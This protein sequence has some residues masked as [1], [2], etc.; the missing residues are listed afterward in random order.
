VAASHPFFIKQG[1][2]LSVPLQVLQD[3]GTPV[4]ITGATLFSEIRDPYGALVATPTLTITNAAQGQFTY[5]A[6]SSTAWPTGQLVSDIYIDLASLP[7]FTQTF[8]IMVQAS[9]TQIGDQNG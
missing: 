8:F 6:Q 9:V 7:F 1:A 2:L 4:N 5:S 3:D